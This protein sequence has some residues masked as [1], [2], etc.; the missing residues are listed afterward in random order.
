MLFFFFFFPR[1][2]SL[3]AEAHIIFIFPYFFIARGKICC[4]NHIS[5]CAA[6]HRY[7]RLAGNKYGKHKSV[8]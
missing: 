1:H 8:D 2:D 7:Q 3:Y 6:A 4:R 5:N